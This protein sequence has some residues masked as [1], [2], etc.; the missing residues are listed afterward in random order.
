MAPL[1]E[2]DRESVSLFVD[3]MKAARDQRKWSQAELGRQA[4]YS[5][6]AIAMVE[7]FQRPPTPSLAKV[8]DKAFGTP[9]TFTRLERRLRNLPFPAAFRSF[10]P[11]E[12]EAAALRSFEHS[13][14]AGLL[15]TPEY[16]R[17]VLETKPNA[18]DDMIDGYVSARLARQSVLTREDPPVPLVY[19]LVDEGALHRP[20]APPPVM[21]DQL[22][23]L[24]DLSRKPHVTIQVVPYDA[25]GHSGLLGAFVI[26][27]RPRDGSIVFI[28][29]V[30]GGRV[31]EDAATV[32]EAAL[33]FDAL[34][35][36]ALPKSTSR[37]LMESVA[38]T[39]KEPAP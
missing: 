10:T 5:E 34:R 23:H 38:R 25:R 19:A 27:D 1:S 21:H 3:E 18:S 35:S 33:C 28:E 9:G 36:E 17:A 8:L 32:A 7:S 39:W 29:D 2:R 11:Y 13:L 31:S 30:T 24:V 14:V 15:Q 16:A 26:A 20:V 4:G 22:A 37:T 6:S 12:A